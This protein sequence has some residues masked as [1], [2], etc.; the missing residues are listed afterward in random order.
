MHSKIVMASGRAF[1]IP[2]FDPF[3]AAHFND[4]SSLVWELLRQINAEDMYERY[5]PRKD[6]V[7]LDSTATLPMVYHNPITIP[8]GSRVSARCFGVGGAVTA[9]L[10][11]TVFE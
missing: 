7:F 3:I 8:Q 10:W 5:F 4:P 1:E 9:S 6:M 11:L 2:L